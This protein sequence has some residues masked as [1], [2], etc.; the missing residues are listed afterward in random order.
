MGRARDRASA[1]LNGQE[2]IL[3]ADADT[4]ISA[5]TDDQIDIKIA[6]ADD[7]Q[8]TANTFTAQSG[9]TIAAQALTATTITASDAVTIQTADNDTQLTLISTDADANVAP[10]LDLTRDSSS[11]ADDD[12]IGRIRFRGENDASEVINYAAI[13]AVIKDVTD[14]TEDGR[15]DIRTFVAGTERSRILINETETVFNEDSVDVDFRIESNA[16]S[17]ALFVDADN[18]SV[19]VAGSDVSVAVTNEA[20]DFI[21]GSTS[22]SI[23]G[24]TIANSSTGYGSIN[25]SDATSGNGRIAAY[26]AYDHN[27]DEWVFGGQG[28]GNTLFKIHDNGRW[29]QFG[30]N[31]TSQALHIKNDGN[32]TNR[33]GM[34][35][36]CGTDDN[37]GTNTAISFDDGD[38][39]G[40]GSITFSGGT[41]TY[42]AFTAHHEISLPNADKTNGYD[43]GTL[44]DIDQIYYAKNR[45]GTE[46]S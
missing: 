14:G 37:S 41:V 42:G 26:I 5:D 1:D 13:N 3:D 15:L 36:Q 32:N 40:Q 9:S 34:I 17:H 24:M 33:K 4:S 35:V 30:C 44:V 10:T 39:S 25:F 38:G 22:K 11:P 31:T 19:L 45:N 16:K 23:G 12:F 29:E 28:Q 6:G 43:Y 46:L 7:F 20:D 2:F 8:F 27:N 21:I 18:D